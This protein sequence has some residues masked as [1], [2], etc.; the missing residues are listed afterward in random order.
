MHLRIPLSLTVAAVCVGATVGAQVTASAVAVGRISGSPTPPN[1]IQDGTDIT[2]GYSL[3]AR[4][5]VQCYSH[6]PG[7]SRSSASSLSV[8]QSP[9][10]VAVR[11]VQSAASIPGPSCFPNAA[12]AGIHRI[13]IT[14]QSPTPVV[15]SLFLRATS[16]YGWGGLR[17]DPAAFAEVTLLDPNGMAQPEVLIR[18]DT[19]GNIVALERPIEVGPAGV[20]L[21]IAGKVEGRW[22]CPSLI[23]SPADQEIEVTF[24]A[25]VF[26]R[27]RPEGADCGPGLQS[28]IQVR[29]EAQG[30]VP[31][32]QLEATSL[33]G[34]SAAFFGIGLSD[35]AIVIPPTNCPLRT[36]L[37]V[38]LP[39]MVG[40]NG[41]ASL[42]IDLPPSAFGA[43]V[44]TQFLNGRLQG[45]VQ[46]WRTSRAYEVTLR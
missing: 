16:S 22:D 42:A 32:L 45:G 39:A 5:T 37:L 3:S 17:E 44:R 14:L 20:Q 4:E 38:A 9:S 26:P 31:S 34:W 19:R 10:T 41:E 6:L 30:L 28:G 7:A 11:F 43:T 1:P 36:D 24:R 35:P 8:D 23:C 46:E 15:G 18:Y 12:V 29:K 33:P 2:A 21:L 40:A 25:N 27:V 13:R